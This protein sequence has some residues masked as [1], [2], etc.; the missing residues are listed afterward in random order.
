MKR[1]Y[2]NL[3]AR[4]SKFKKRKGLEVSK[5]YKEILG[6]SREYLGKYIESVF[7]TQFCNLKYPSN[8]FI[9]V[10]MP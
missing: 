7:G 9:A 6:C 5:S 2:K 4:A 8:N 3:M 1:M 10:K